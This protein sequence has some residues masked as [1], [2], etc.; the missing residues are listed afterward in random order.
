MAYRDYICCRDCKSKFIYDGNDSIRNALEAAYGDENA[1]NWTV[2]LVCPDCLEKLERPTVVEPDAYGYA[3]R[4]ATHIWQTHYKDVSPQ[5]K[6]LDDLLGVLTQIDNMTVGLTRQQAE[7]AAPTVVEPAHSDHPLQHWDRTCPACA[8]EFTVLE[9]VAWR[10]QDSR[11]HYR[12]CGYKPGFD[13]DYSILRP[14]P[15]YLAATPPRA[16]LTVDQIIEATRH[17]DSNAP[18]LFVV[19]ARAVEAAHGIGETK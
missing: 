7:P 10:Y 13:A 1:P 17:I 3:S 6:P 14:V 15:L 11:G 8:A 9:P 18:G 19:I 16:A 4:L 12:Y 2:K 5:W